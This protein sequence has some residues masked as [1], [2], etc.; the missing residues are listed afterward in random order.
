MPPTPIDPVA[1]KLYILRK[2]LEKHGFTPGCLGCASVRNGT[3]PQLPHSDECRQRIMK[4]V[5][6]TDD[7]KK[8]LQQAEE[9]ANEY[10]AKR[11]REGATS[12][13]EPEKGAAKKRPAEEAADDSER[14]TR[15]SQPE[16]TQQERILSLATTP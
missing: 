3:Q 13:T 14:T 6:K 4:E 9:R 16:P 5:E 2:D 15:L 11:V 10:L 12:S 8:R 1:R 7:G